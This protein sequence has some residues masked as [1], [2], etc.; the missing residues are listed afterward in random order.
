M[1]NSLPCL[2]KGH[3]NKEYLFLLWLIDN[4]E[5]HGYK[6]IQI[7]K[8]AGFTIATPA[9]VYGTLEKMRGEGLVIQ[10]ESMHGKRMRKEYS[11]TAKGRAFI[12]HAKKNL[13]AGLMGEFLKEMML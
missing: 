2:P 5:N 4:K 6:I 1:N 12:K 11:L 9:R 8:K 3:E 7:L 10:R 13:F